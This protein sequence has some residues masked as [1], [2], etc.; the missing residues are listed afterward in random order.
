MKKPKTKNRKWRHLL[1]YICRGCGKK[2]SSLRWKRAQ[3]E[4]CTLCNPGFV[5]DKTIPM[6]K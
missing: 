3:G 2:R 6:F 1:Q 4:L 5:D